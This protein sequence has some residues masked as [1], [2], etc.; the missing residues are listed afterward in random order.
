MLEYTGDELKELLSKRVQEKAILVI[1]NKYQIH[2]FIESNSGTYISIGSGDLNDSLENYLFEEKQRKST[3]WIDVFEENITNTD[4]SNLQNKEKINKTKVKSWKKIRDHITLGRKG[5]ISRST[6]LMVGI[7][8]A[9]RCQMCGD[10]LRKSSIPGNQANYGYLAHIVASSNDGPRGN[11]LLPSGVDVNDTENLM[12]LCDKCHRLIDRVAPNDYPADKLRRIRED[13]IKEVEYLL[14]SLVYLKVNMLVVLGNVA[15][16]TAIFDEQKAIE[17]M[18]LRKLQKS[19]SLQKI[20]DVKDIGSAH[21]LEYWGSLFL[22][23]ERKIPIFR[24]LLIGTAGGWNNN[25]PLAIFPLHKVSVLILI[26]RIIGDSRLVYL[27]QPNRN[28]SPEEYG[29][30]WSWPANST[31]PEETKYNINILKET[32]SNNCLSEALLILNLTASIDPTELPNDIYNKGYCLPS[33]EITVQKPSHD[34]ISHA[35]DLELIRLKIDEAI[36]VLQDQW[37]I[38]TIHLFVVAPTTVCIC[39]GQKMQARHHADY[40]LYERNSI[41]KHFEKTIK[42]TSSQALFKWGTP[43]ERVISIS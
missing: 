7:L 43:E 3:Y 37:H 34:V 33:L 27:F 25:L 28:N 20:E 15:G 4:P 5:D 14:K 39:I 26:G 16:Q 18:W 21:L 22:H 32:T 41:S 12:H 19:S 9:W 11:D 40:I 38:K 31:L 35:K 10:D 24:D 2:I 29:G 1:A 8:S 6:Q 30:R 17:A 23:L 13:R 36:C 42:I